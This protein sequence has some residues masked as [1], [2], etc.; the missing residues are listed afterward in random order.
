MTRQSDTVTTRMIK[1]AIAERFGRNDEYM[2][3]YEV[4]SEDKTRANY[5]DV[6]AVCNWPS[7]G[8]HVI[9]FEVK[10]SRSDWLRE[11][12]KP[13]KAEAFH[14]FC[15]NWYIAAVP[16]VV[17]HEELP[18]G[19][20]LIEVKEGSS[21]VV[22]KPKPNPNVVELSHAMA[23]RIMRRLRDGR[24]DEVIRYA[25]KYTK[26]LNAGFNERV[27]RETRYQVEEARKVKEKAR[28]IAAECGID[29]IH[30]WESAKSIAQDIKVA[31]SIRKAM[32]AAQHARNCLHS[33]DREVGAALA[34]FSAASVQTEESTP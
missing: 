31:K 6:L 5:A 24:S 34:A 16:G 3:A 30:S 4:A 19:W 12:S 26:A 7:R 18:P 13:Q 8:M 32:E 15:I 23:V 14:R 20:G 22:V 21:R 33:A 11:L 28:Q 17:K 25:E 9:G 2:L 29:L 1:E 27:Q 10:A